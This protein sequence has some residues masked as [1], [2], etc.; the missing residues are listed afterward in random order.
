M[1]TIFKIEGIPKASKELRKRQKDYRKRAQIVLGEFLD[2]VRK[3][4]IHSIIPNVT[5]ET[6]PY[7]AKRGPKGQ[8]STP[9][10]LTSRTGKMI[11]LLGEQFHKK[12]T[13]VGGIL[14]KKNTAAFKLQ[15]RTIRSQKVDRG[16]IATIRIYISYVP[17]QIR[18]IDSGRERKLPKESKLTLKMRFL[19]E[20]GIRGNKRIYMAP[21]A[22]RKFNKLRSN[23]KIVINSKLGGVL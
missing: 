5:G 9:G 13:G 6:H 23:L 11:W 1:P 18:K 8:K 7:Y 15:V 16:F 17:P 20:T 3:G 14:Y 21:S 4:A 19:W 2:E 10:K 12:F 22:K